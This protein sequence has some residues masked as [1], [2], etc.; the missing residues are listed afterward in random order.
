MRFGRVEREWSSSALYAVLWQS[1][2]RN[3]LIEIRFKGV[4]GFLSTENRLTT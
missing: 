2:D 4:G 3:R 1:L